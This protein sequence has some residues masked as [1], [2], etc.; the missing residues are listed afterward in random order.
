MANRKIEVPNDGEGRNKRQRYSSPRIIHTE[1]L[2]ARATTCAKADSTCSTGG[3]NGP[4][5]S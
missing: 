2:Q 5:Q 1:K 4:L 3:Q